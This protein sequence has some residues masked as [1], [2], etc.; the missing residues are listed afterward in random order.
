M[1]DIDN[2]LETLVQKVADQDISAGKE[3]NEILEY[4]ST[5]ISESIQPLN[6]VSAPFVYRLLTEYAQAVKKY[7]PEEIKMSDYLGE[8]QMTMIML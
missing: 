3:L 5:K 7:F 1:K 8:T 4:Y 2:L 6:A